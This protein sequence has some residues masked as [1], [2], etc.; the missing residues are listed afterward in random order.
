MLFNIN[1]GATPA[2]ATP[3]N[4][5]QT[6]VNGGDYARRLRLTTVNSQQSTDN[7]QRT[8]IGMTTVVC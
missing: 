8:T 3:D 7:G 2:E 1:G 4:G 5:Q 6:T